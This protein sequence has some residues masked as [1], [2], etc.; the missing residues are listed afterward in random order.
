MFNYPADILMFDHID[1]ESQFNDLLGVYLSR[2]ADVLTRNPP[3]PDL[4]SMMVVFQVI[5]VC[6]HCYFFGTH[7]HTCEFTFVHNSLRD[8]DCLY[9][10][11]KEGQR[12]Q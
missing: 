4:N 8:R 9:D 10:S 6:Q 11:S 5:K 3:K 1:A 12:V 2:C 7:I